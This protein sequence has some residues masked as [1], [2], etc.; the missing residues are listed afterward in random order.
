MLFQQMNLWC[1]Y[2]WFKLRNFFESEKGA[3]DIIAIV[4]LIGI[5]VLVAIVFKDQLVKLINDLFE[6][7]GLQSK[8]AVTDP[9][10]TGD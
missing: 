7:I 10:A 5:V 9:V 2:I 4:V 1:N 8:Q 3:V 6:A